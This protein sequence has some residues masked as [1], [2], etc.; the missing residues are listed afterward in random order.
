MSKKEQ[1]KKRQQKV[2]KS[3]MM[4]CVRREIE[5]KSEKRGS[6]KKR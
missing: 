2:T 5:R 6:R 1:I 3:I 4:Y